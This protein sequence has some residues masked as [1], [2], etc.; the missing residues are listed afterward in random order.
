MNRLHFCKSILDISLAKSHP[1]IFYSIKF[2]EVVLH[3]VH[4]SALHTRN[5]KKPKNGCI[6][7]AKLC[8]HILS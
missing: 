7:A 4:N 5:W 1:C 2:N 6:I 8:Q 3:N